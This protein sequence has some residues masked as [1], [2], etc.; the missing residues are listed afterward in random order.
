VAPGVRRALSTAGAIAV[1]NA[2]LSFRNLWPTPAFVWSGEVSVE[3]AIFLL[4]MIGAAYVFGRPS[5]AAIRWI[6]AFWVLLAFGHYADVTGPA[7]YGRDINLYWDIRYMPDVAAMIAHAAP[8]WLIVG[9]AAVV[10]A[11][12]AVHVLSDDQHPLPVHPNAAIPAGLEQDVPGTSVRRSI[13][14]PRVRA[15]AG[16]DELRSWVRQ[17]DLL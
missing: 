13:D 17:R 11:I 6:A 2:S 9:V 5:R 7:L 10:G 1:L 16:L 15:A 14:R 3:C 4:L 12:A 8:L